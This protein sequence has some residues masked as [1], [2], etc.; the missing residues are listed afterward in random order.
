M[1]LYD[2]KLNPTYEDVLVAFLPIKSVKIKC[3]IIKGVKIR[4][5]KKAHAQQIAHG[6]K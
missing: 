3:V 2:D 6:R 4:R 5:Q 1:G